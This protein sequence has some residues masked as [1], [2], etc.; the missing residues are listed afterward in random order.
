MEALLTNR[1]FHV[2]QD[3]AE[4]IDDIQKAV[5]HGEVTN[6]LSTRP[7]GDIEVG[8]P[9]Y[10]DW[11]YMAFK[12]CCCCRSREFT[13]YNKVVNLGNSNFKLDMD[14]VRTIRRFRMH[15]FGLNFIL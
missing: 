8:V 14:V 15:G 1:L 4:L 6:K 5:P 9:R 12:V 3:S 13:E 11:E 10:L 2:S 7:N